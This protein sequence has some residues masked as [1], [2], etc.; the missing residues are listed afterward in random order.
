M[1]YRKIENVVVDGIDHKDYPD[2]CD[3]YISSADY[4]GKEMT[5]EQLDEINEDSDLVYD[6][7]IKQVF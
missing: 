2:F 3:A 1:D 5:E 6:Y 7:V 4:D